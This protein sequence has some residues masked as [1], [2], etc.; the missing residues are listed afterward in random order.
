[1]ETMDMVI[2]ILEL[3]AKGR[4]PTPPASPGILSAESHCAEKPKRFAQI[5]P[6]DPTDTFLLSN[7]WTSYYLF[8]VC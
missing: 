8:R 1:M 5:S 2:D 3:P 4:T 6:T 7:R